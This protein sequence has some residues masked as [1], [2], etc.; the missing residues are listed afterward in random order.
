MRNFRKS[1]EPNLSGSGEWH[2]KLFHI[3]SLYPFFMA[4][5]HHYP[6]IIS[7]ISLQFQMNNRIYFVMF[8]KAKIPN[9]SK[10]KFNYM[11]FIEASN[12][13]QHIKLDSKFK[14]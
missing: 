4:M 7:L 11:Y 6:V 12:H 8:N 9:K 10:M 1:D 13:V 2:G 5:R 3:I 14:K